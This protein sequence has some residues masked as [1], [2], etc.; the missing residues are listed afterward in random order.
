MDFLSERRKL[1]LGRG[2]EK[3]DQEGERR[4]K[5]KVDCGVNR[6]QA[7]LGQTPAGQLI[8]FVTLVDLCVASLSL[9]FIIFRMGIT[10]L[11]LQSCCGMR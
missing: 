5:R 8:S 10:V 3:K 6:H 2:E 7:N 11:T 9:Y 1:R 4:W